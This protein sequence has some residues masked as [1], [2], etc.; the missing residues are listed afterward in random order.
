[1][2][3]SWKKQLAPSRN[4]WS[5]WSQWPSWAAFQSDW[6]GLVIVLLV[7]IHPRFEA[8]GC[9]FGSIFELLSSSLCVSSISNLQL[10]WTKFAFQIVQCAFHP[11]NHQRS[12]RPANGLIRPLLVLRR[13]P[14]RTQV[15]LYFELT[16]NMRQSLKYSSAKKNLVA[17]AK[18]WPRFFPEFS[19]DSF[20]ASFAKNVIFFQSRI[21][22]LFQGTFG[23]CL[24]PVLS[25][26]VC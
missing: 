3:D 2:G 5:F 23:L 4:S 26:K 1:M 16:A 19:F 7:E 8:F 20:L 10:H 13:M 15:L 14:R 17:A 12:H 11:F 22:W 9:W 21:R 18:D 6:L 25:V 24:E